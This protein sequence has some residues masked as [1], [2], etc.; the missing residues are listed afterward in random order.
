V[1]VPEQYSAR[2]IDG[3]VIDIRRFP[4][5]SPHGGYRPAAHVRRPARPARLMSSAGLAPGQIRGRVVDVNDAVIP[6]ATVE[7]RVGNY[8]ASIVSDLTGGFTFS[9]VPHGSVELSAALMGFATQRTSFS[10]DG[11]PR[12]IEMTLEVGRLEE[13]VTVTG[14]APV[15]DASTS[16]RFS[17]PSQNVV[18]LQARAAGV[19][20]IRVDV[21]RAGVSH[22]FVKPLVVGSSPEVR[23]RYKR[24]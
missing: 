17:A 13:T 19:L 21:P 4:L 15:I 2:A 1:F 16:A 7:I 5:T 22:E 11:S 20:P 6:G 24:N 12:Q 14:A 18:N 9:G 3:N 10:F 23:L 8:I